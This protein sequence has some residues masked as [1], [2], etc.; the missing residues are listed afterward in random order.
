MIFFIIL[1]SGCINQPEIDPEELLTN[2][3][4]KFSSLKTMEALVFL[5][6]SSSLSSS[7]STYSIKHNIVENKFRVD[8]QNIEPNSMAFCIVNDTDKYYF[9]QDGSLSEIGFC[10]TGDPSVESIKEILPNSKNFEY[11]G[12]EIV[13]GELTH[14]IL[15]N[16]RG[17]LMSVE[18]YGHTKDLGPE[19]DIDATVWISDKNQIPI[20]LKTIYKSEEFDAIITIE[21]GYLE[22][23]INEALSNDYFEK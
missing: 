19:L 21:S 17:P 12:T 4:N 20:K 2:S 6:Y 13:S 11:I 8:F 15:F 7:Y 9:R 18:L 22:Y 14:K 23:T 5:N 3:L 16:S 1:V 10:L